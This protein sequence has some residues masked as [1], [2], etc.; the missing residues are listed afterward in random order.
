MC[1]G[2]DAGSNAGSPTGEGHGSR[3]QNT[4]D[5]ASVAEERVELLCNDQILDPNMDLRTVKEFIW[6]VKNND[7]VLHYRPLR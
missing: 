5:S 4:E 7:L 2:S 1:G 6:K 3:G